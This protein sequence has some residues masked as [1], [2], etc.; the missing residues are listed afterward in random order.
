MCGVN[1]EGKREVLA[2]EPMYKESE[3]SY[4]AL[5]NSLKKRGLK[6]VW[7]AVSDARCAEL[8]IE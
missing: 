3:A 6:N 4:T 2:V 8:L 1:L 7:L 5:F